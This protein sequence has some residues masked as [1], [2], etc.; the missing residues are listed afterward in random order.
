MTIQHIKNCLQKPLSMIILGTIAFFL[1]FLNFSIYFLSGGKNALIGVEEFSNFQEYS[2]ALV[3]GKILADLDNR[4]DGSSGLYAAH[5]ESRDW[6]ASSELESYYNNPE[7]RKSLSFAEYKS[8]TGL[9]GY[10]FSFL[11]NKL[12]IPITLLQFGNALLLSGTIMGIVVL[13]R[14][15]FNFTACFSTYIV[16]LLSPWI[17][18]FAKNLYWVEFTWFLPV[19]CSLLLCSKKNP[20]PFSLLLFLTITIKCLCGFEYISVIISSAICIVIID[21]IINK[22]SPKNQ[23]LSRL[24]LSITAC[25]LGFFAAL[26][27]QS[28]ILGKGDIIAGFHQFYEATVSKRIL[29]GSSNSEIFQESLQAPPI[30]V[31]ISYFNWNT[32]IITGLPGSLFGVVVCLAFVLSLIGIII[33]RPNALQRCAILM[34]LFIANTSWF[35]LASPHSYIHHHMN[36]VLWY[37][38]FIQFCI[39][40]IIDAGFFVLHSLGLPR[41][42]KSPRQKQVPSYNTEA[43]KEKSK[44]YCVLIPVVNE[45][46]RIVKELTRAKAAKIQ[47]SVDIIICDGNSTDGSMEKVKKLDIC[48]ILT[49]TGPGKQGAQLRIGLDYALKQ[50]YKG[51]VTIDGNNKDSIEDIPFFIKKLRQGYDFVQGSRFIAGGQAINT[52]FYR[53]VAVKLLHAPLISLTAGKKYT[54][55]TNAFRAYSVRYLKHKSVKPFR[56]IFSGYELLAYLSVRADQLGLKTCEIPVTRSYPPRG[57]TPTKISPIRGNITLF[58]ILFKNAFGAYDPQEVN[59]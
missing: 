25:L 27:V 6:I 11:F 48:A 51:I 21:S 35:I 45:G 38:G 14:K 42:K 39:Y 46:E 19:L 41:R 3:D 34:L 24:I 13:I 47:N 43:I 49:K 22:E 15:K 18:A 20:I 26:G 36:Y 12:H 23:K 53:T 52:P 55:T 2:E 37:F 32:D 59:K 10:I 28:A 5:D 4:S 50:G 29:G 30:F 33:S 9:Q 40:L 1:L 17:C 8:Q 31:L 44:N 54:D 16:F 7:A 57:K 56:D 58:S